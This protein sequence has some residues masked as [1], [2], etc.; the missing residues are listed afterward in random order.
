MSKAR[1][2][3]ILWVSRLRPNFLR[4]TN[5]TEATWRLEARKIDEWLLG[6]FWATLGC[7]LWLRLDNS[8][9]VLAGVITHSTLISALE[10][11]K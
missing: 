7:S 2:A 9:M 10:E 6:G 8:W 5:P 4:F 3:M 1:I 11:G